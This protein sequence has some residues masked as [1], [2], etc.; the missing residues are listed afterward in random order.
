MPVL[1]SPFDAGPLGLPLLEVPR[2]SASGTCHWDVSLVMP[3]SQSGHTHITGTLPSEY[4]SL[5]PSLSHLS[6]I[7]CASYSQI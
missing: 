3:T 6:Q 1:A 5:P 7:W 2:K 4:W